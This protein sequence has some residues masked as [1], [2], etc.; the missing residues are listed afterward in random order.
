MTRYQG[1]YGLVRVL[2]PVLVYTTCDHSPSTPKG[3]NPFTKSPSF[4]SFLWGR[5]TKKDPLR[6]L[7]A[8]MDFLPFERVEGDEHGAPNKTTCVAEVR[9]W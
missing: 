7:W 1:T 9:S 6:A 3:S 8:S 4:T 5:P 2:Q